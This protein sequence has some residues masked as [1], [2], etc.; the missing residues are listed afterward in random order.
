MTST[1]SAWDSAATK[2]ALTARP[3]L[4]SSLWAGMTTVRPGSGRAMPVRLLSTL[5][6]TPAVPPLV[7]S[8]QDGVRGGGCLPGEPRARRRPRA[9]AHAVPGPAPRRSAAD[10]TRYPH[11]GDQRQRQ[12]GAD[13]QFG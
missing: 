13:D 7:D 6:E 1:F 2:A 10:G 12:H 11:H 4:P 9:G 5:E 3:T 8:A